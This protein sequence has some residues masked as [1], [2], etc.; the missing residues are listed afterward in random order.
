M[1]TPP[2]RKGKRRD[3]RAQASHPLALVAHTLS[4]SVRQTRKAGAAARCRGP[5]GQKTIKS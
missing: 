5:K 2:S 4:D 3:P 1:A